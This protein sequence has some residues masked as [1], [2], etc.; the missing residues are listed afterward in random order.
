[1]TSAMVGTAIKYLFMVVDIILV[2]EIVRAI[3][4][5]SLR[6]SYE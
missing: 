5:F 3:L 4:V 2:Y 1:M 6:D